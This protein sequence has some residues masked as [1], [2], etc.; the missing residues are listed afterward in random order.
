MAFEK[1]SYTITTNSGAGGSITRNQSVKHGESVGITATP[2]TG[3]Q[4]SAWSGSCGTFSTSANPVSFTATKDCSI[5]VAFEKVSYT[6]ATNSGAGGSITGNQS[7]GHEESVSITATPDTGY[8]V[9]SWSGSCGTF[10][11]STNP[12]TFTAAKDCSIS[13]GL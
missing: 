13:C 11:T 3:Y 1:L 7:V 9:Q 2:N 8:R 6:I 4:I 12:A 5:S 10:S